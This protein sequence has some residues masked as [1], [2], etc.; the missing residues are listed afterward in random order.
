MT[1]EST[2][3]DDVLKYGLGVLKEIYKKAKKKEDTGLM[4]NIADRLLLLYESMSDTEK[5]KR[6]H[7]L[8]FVRV[9]SEEDDDRD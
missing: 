3:S 5:S 6:G 8:G 2:S 4:L 1:F 9:A 7:Q